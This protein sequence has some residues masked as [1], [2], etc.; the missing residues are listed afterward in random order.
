MASADKRIAA[1]KGRYRNVRVNRDRRSRSRADPDAGQRAINLTKTRK[2][3]TS[4]GFSVYDT[5]G[6]VKRPLS[7]DP[8]TYGRQIPRIA[9]RISEIRKIHQRHYLIAAVIRN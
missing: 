5:I 9:R 7:T 3:L 8:V 1:V 6:T 4:R 2:P